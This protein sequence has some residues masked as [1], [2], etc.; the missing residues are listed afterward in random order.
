MPMS[1][2][3]VEQSGDVD[4]FGLHNIHIFTGIGCDVIVVFLESKT[5]RRLAVRAAVATLLCDS[6]CFVRLAVIV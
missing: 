1:C 4:S 2:W 3:I 6:C 5:F